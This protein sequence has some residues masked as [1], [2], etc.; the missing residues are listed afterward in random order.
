MPKFITRVELHQATSED[1]D[2][3]HNEMAKRNFYRLIISDEG[4]HYQLPT[5][6]YFASG[7]L[8]AAQVREIARA[9]AGV[10]GR[11][12]WVLVCEFN[13]AAWYLREA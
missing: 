5:A 12:C 7:E 10:T 6:E 4:H 3:L 13:S 8:S 11:S 1:Y 9:A 2:T